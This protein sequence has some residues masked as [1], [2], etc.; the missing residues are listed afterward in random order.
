MKMLSVAEFM[1]EGMGLGPDV[2]GAPDMEKFTLLDCPAGTVCAI[3]GAPVARGYRAADVV[4]SNTSEYLDLLGGRPNGF[5]S[6]AAARAFKG[7][8]NMGSRAFLYDGA[9]MRA[10]HPL[11][12][13]TSADKADGRTSWSRLA[14]E[15]WPRYRGWACVFILATDYKK[16]VWPTAIPGMLG[17]HTPVLVFDADTNVLRAVYADWERLVEALDFVEAVLG[18][19]FRKYSLRSCLFTDAK[20][21]TA[22]GPSLVAR[23]EEQLTVLRGT[24]E[25]TIVNIIAQGE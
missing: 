23:L 25:W 17:V 4:P 18:L 7:S 10:Y 9:T 2:P 5:V 1:V 13:N 8:W 11:I 16:K 12:S 3:T 22:V 15:V 20:T 19:G 21:T 6:E 14:R 24:P